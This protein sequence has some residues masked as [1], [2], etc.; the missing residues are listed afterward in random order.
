[1][2]WTCPRCDREFD[3]ARQAHTCLPAGT[4]EQTFAGAPPPLRDTYDVIL[5]HLL[6]LGPVHEDAV[7]VGVFLKHDRKLAEVRPRS[8]DLSLALCLPRRVHHPRIA[9]IMNPDGQR[10]WNVLLVRTPDDVDDQVQQWLTEA[11]VYAS[12]GI[13]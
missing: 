2:R 12:D 8:R 6:T 13:D 7:A 5:A 9:R 3:R 4:V 11:Y 1:V 10:V